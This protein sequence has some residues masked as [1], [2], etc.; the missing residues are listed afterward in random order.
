MQRRRVTLPRPN[1]TRVDATRLTIT[2]VYDWNEEREQVFTGASPET[3]DVNTVFGGYSYRARGDE[4]PEHHV[5][6]NLSRLRGDPSVAALYMQYSTGEDSFTLSP[7][8]SPTEPEVALRVLALAQP[9]HLHCSV[10][11]RLAGL[12]GSNL[13]FPLPVEVAGPKGAPQ[14]FEIRGVRAA[15][16]GERD[17]Q[18]PDYTFTMDRL[19][20]Q[21]VNLDV[22]FDTSGS[23]DQTLLNRILTQARKIVDPLVGL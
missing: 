9:R 10:A 22:S 21:D 14:V 20:G 13:W 1:L 18:T 2:A 7:P 3:G 5:F 11:F 4:R 12:E 15:A 8:S 16:Y 17:A 19:S 6:V 23:V